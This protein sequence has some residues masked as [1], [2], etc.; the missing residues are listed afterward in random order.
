M[1]LRRVA[2]DVHAPTVDRGV[3]GY[4]AIVSGHRVRRDW[5]SGA[6]ERL[7]VDT[8]DRRRGDYA[9][10]YIAVAELRLRTPAAHQF[11]R[12]NSTCRE[13]PGDDPCGHIMN[14]CSGPVRPQAE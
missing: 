14:R 2:R 10:Q 5:S 12:P 7:E 1:S 11:V 9:D 6:S 4:S 3:Y 8:S 13:R